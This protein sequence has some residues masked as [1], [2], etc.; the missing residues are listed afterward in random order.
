MSG[1]VAKVEALFLEGPFEA[2]CSAAVIYLSMEGTSIPAYN[3]VRK[4]AERAVNASLT[5][6]TDFERKMKVLEVLPQVSELLF[7]RR[8]MVRV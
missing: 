1:L 6:I 3:Y 7:L 4:L 5:K 8:V 2:I